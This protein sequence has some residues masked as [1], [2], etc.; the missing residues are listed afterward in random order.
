VIDCDVRAAILTL[1]ARGLGPSAIARAV[2]V[3]RNSVR[4]VVA[5]GSAE[6]PRLERPEQLVP[7]VELVRDLHRRCKDNVVRVHEELQAQGVNV[8]YSTLTVFCRR[9]E[10]GVKP[11]ERAGRYH[12]EP[13]EEMQHDTSPHD[14]E[15]G[16]R[17]RRVQCASL[18]L[19][20]SR[21]LF[22]QLY[23]RWTRFEARVFLTR[24]LVYLGGAADRCM[25]DNST[26]II[27]SGT[28]A[29]AVPAPAM[30]ALADRFD[31]SFVAHE[32]GDANRSARV[33]RPFDYIE[34]NFYA[35]REFEDIA[36]ANG[37]LVKWCARSNAR[38]RR[39]LK[40]SP[41]ELYA[42][43]RSA[44]KP[45]P[46]FIPEVYDLHS[47]RVDVEGYVNLHRNRYSVDAH[48]IGRQVEVRETVERVRIFDGHRLAEEHEKAPYGAALRLTLDKHR[49]QTRRRKLPPPP[50]PI[51]ALLREQGPELGALIDALRK[52]HGGRALRAVRELHRLW[53][54][55][56]S[57]AL[58]EAVEEALGFGLTDVSRIERMVLRR[59]AKTVF[60]LP[61]HEQGDDDDR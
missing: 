15:L 21:M 56:P 2:G 45:L 34:R 20:F 49:G 4:S 6:V 41:H 30:K 44:L 42:V 55:Y 13:G 59:L 9:H 24:A 50:T 16:G 52:R 14:V 51:E 11:K 58:R 46:V 36:D 25:L 17:V 27:A 29:D 26:V 10:I 12:F 28:G 37:Q 47:R 48:L 61:L 54:D 53:R 1:H 5:S 22:A 57:D 8:A 33:E 31:F 38:Y 32:L 60:K 23:E 19:C 43:E 7:Y 39:H 40:A 18:V 35:G 3:A